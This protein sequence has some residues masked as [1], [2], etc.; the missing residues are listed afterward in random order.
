MSV[1]KNILWSTAEQ[2][3]RIGVAFF[4]NIF[5]ARTLGPGEYGVF[6][7]AMATAAIMG[8]TALLGL[9]LVAIREISSEQSSAGETILTTLY[10]RLGASILILTGVC[11]WYYYFL[12]G[13]KN[14]NYPSVLFII[15]LLIPFQ[16]IGC[17]IGNCFVATLQS[18]LATFAVS[19]SLLFATIIRIQGIHSGADIH[20]FANCYLFEFVLATFI[21]SLLF[22]KKSSSHFNYYR[23]SWPHARSLLS[24]SKWLLMS[25]LVVG[26]LQNIG[27]FFM[28]A[29]ASQTQIGNYAA[30]VRLVTSLQFLPGLIGQSFVPVIAKLHDEG[31]GDLLYLERELFRLLWMVG[32]LICGMFLLAGPLLVP[33]LLGKNY[34]GAIGLVQILALSIIPISLGAARAVIFSKIRNYRSILISDATGA[35]VTLLFSMLLMRPLGPEGIAAAAVLGSIVA[36]IAVPMI[37][38][39]DQATFAL[40]MKAALFPFPNIKFLLS[41]KFGV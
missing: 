21:I 37:L 28:N 23:F 26:I 11:L 22:L 36:Y 3:L 32:Y 39:R 9:D 14:G 34:N 16:A 38:M 40:I 31:S 6:A 33:F 19:V 41:G 30:A 17:T 25:A 8:S 15:V 13:D 29:H 10:L 5:I 4:V 12:S 2:F 7:S 24:K 27:L 18:K 35:I 20:F 1:G